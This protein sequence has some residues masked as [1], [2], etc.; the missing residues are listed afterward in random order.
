MK[1]L[2]LLIILFLSSA[3]FAEQAIEVSISQLKAKQSSYR[4]KKV[5]L[6]GILRFTG[7]RVTN[8]TQFHLKEDKNYGKSYQI[9]FKDSELKN[10]QLVNGKLV[11]IECV[12]LGSFVLK[13]CIFYKPED[14]IVQ[15]EDFIEFGKEEFLRKWENSEELIEKVSNKSI[16]ISSYYPFERRNIYNGHRPD[17]DLEMRYGDM[18]NYMNV[19]VP[20]KIRKQYESIDEGDLVDFYFEFAIN[21]KS[22]RR[23]YLKMTHFKVTDPYKLRVAKEFNSKEYQEDRKNDPDGYEDKY[24]N[25]KYSI[26]G[27]ITRVPNRASSA[28]LAYTIRDGS[29]SI[30][31]FFDP[32]MENEL[33]HYREGRIVSLHGF[34]HTAKYLH[35]YNCQRKP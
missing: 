18:S 27:K 20:L 35:L 13:D 16:K 25:T 26:R 32:S 2:S 24:K 8:R 9:K 12:V 3:M 19:T 31:C 5:L 4:G 21:E 28:G 15:N 7:K 23:N 6:T 14:E 30:T 17:E 34:L 10:E 33:R 1:Y 11:T 22:S 29:S